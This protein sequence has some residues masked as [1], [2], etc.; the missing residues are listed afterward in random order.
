M[1]HRVVSDDERR[2]LFVAY[3][4]YRKPQTS[5]STMQRD[6]LIA[7]ALDFAGMLLMVLSMLG[8]TGLAESIAPSLSSPIVYLGLGGLGLLLTLIAMPRIFRASRAMSAAR[9]KSD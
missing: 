6:L 8:F 3:L 7:I 5:P 4:A 2:L 1:V 9:R